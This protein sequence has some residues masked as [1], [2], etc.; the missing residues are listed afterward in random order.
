MRISRR[1]RGDRQ[2]RKARR[3]HERGLPERE[4]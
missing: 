1:R 2:R 3:V 4:L